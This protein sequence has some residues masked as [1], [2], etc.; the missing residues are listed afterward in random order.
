MLTDAEL[1]AHLAANFKMNGGVLD[2]GLSE[3]IAQAKEANALRE[4]LANARRDALESAASYFE[5]T[6]RELWT[7]QVADELRALKEKP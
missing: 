3:A 1:D 5:S 4:Q 2:S 6:H 7:P